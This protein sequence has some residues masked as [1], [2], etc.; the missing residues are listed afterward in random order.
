MPGGVRV[1]RGI[2]LGTLATNTRFAT[3]AVD[4]KDEFQGLGLSPTR[5]SADEHR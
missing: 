1:H 3:A 4:F 5:K 2:R